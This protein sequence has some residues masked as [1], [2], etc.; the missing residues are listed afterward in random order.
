[1]HSG[2]LNRVLLFR[3]DVSEN[4]SSF[5]RFHR[6]VGFHS[7]VVESPLNS[8]F[9]EGY[10]LCPKN[11]VLS[12]G[13]PLRREQLESQKTVAVLLTV[14]LTLTGRYRQ[15][16]NRVAARSFVSHDPRLCNL[17][18]SFV[19]RTLDCLEMFQRVERAGKDHCFA[20]PKG[21]SLATWKFKLQL[22]HSTR[23]YRS[24]Q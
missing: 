9:I 20:T 2:T 21:V 13:M 16:E 19:N 23:V 14:T 3:S 1:M 10:C 17:L 5:S 12:S 4:V 11:T 8:L 22:E 18:H 7:C 6:L 15:V 24:L